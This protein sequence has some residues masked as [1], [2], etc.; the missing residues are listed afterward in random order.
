LRLRFR[1]GARLRAILGPDAAGV[2]QS[3]VALGLNSTSSLVAGAFLGSITGTFAKFP[4]LLVLVPAAIGLRGN[5]FGTFG[6][7]ISTTI[8]SGTFRLSTRPDTALG[9]NVL[10]AGILT[11]A[12]SAVL[13]VVAKVVA[14]ALGLEGTIGVLDLAVISIVG[15]VLGSLVVMAATLGLTAGAVRYG[16][17][18][19]NVTAPLVST[20]GDVLTLPALWLATF[21]LGFAVF[22]SSLGAVLSEA[23]ALVLVY[24]LRTS[25]PELRRIVRES[26]PVLVTAAA[27][28]AM[29]GIT[30]EKRFDDLDAFPALLVLVP[31]FVSSAGALGGVLSGRLSTKLLHG[32]AEPESVPGRAARADI[33][34]VF[35][36]AVPGYLFNG[37]GA[38]YTA[39]LLDERSPGV[40]DMV[41]TSLIGGAFA[42]AFVVVVAY[43]GTIAAFRTGLDPDT[44]G[45]PV[46][47][48]SVDF[49]GALVL[50]L[51][52]AALGIV[53]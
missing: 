15:G 44:Y 46:V 7:R 38:H 41:A 23:A 37:I 42:M 20:L 47:S 13:A 18:L 36:L 31:A 25:L 43:Y 1:P 40:A 48:S 2:R 19:D 30:L 10:A 29:A 16:W 52:I 4:G 35:V 12:M 26:V 9:Q 32:L 27:L 5:I 34:F 51:T 22:S 3:L 11:L 6:S 14:V 24:G 39:L 33:G 45:I 8:H 21:L 50:V 28:S 17:D 53:G 49:V